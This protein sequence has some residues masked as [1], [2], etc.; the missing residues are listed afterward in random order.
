MAESIAQNLIGNHVVHA[1][2]SHLNEKMS[3]SEPKP[4]HLTES[5][6]FNLKDIPSQKL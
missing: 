5:G 2:L 4:D 3:A 6:I 1:P